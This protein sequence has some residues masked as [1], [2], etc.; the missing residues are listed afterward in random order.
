MNEIYQ[1]IAQLELET[2]LDVKTQKINYQTNGADSLLISKKA[3]SNKL[4]VI[5]KNV[6]DANRIEEELSFFAPNIKVEIFQ[7]N[8]VIPYERISPSNTLIANRVS[9]LWNIL[10][11]KLDVVIIQANIIQNTLPPPS[12]ILG[13]VFDFKVGDRLSIAQLRQNLT[14]SEYVLVDKVIAMGE[15]AIRGGVI[16]LMLMGKQDLIRIELFDD[17]IESLRYVDIETNKTISSVDSIQIFPTK[18][19]PVDESA[20]NLLIEQLQNYFVNNV[21][22]NFLIKEL[23]KGIL[24]L[25][26]EFYLP[27]FFTNKPTIFDYLT[28]DYEII[29]F[30]GLHQEL[31]NNYFDIM[32]RYNIYSFQYPCM[33]PIDLYIPTDSIFNKINQF[34]HYKFHRLTKSNDIKLDQISLLPDIGVN[35][36]LG[37]PCHKLEAFITNFAGVV[38]ICLDSIGRLEIIKTTLAKYQIDSIKFKNLI[39]IEASLYNGFICNNIAFITE[40]ELYKLDITPDFRLKRK[41]KQN[42][43]ANNFN[44]DTIVHDLAEININDYVVHITYGIGKYLG[45]ITQ[46]IDNIDYDMLELEYANGSK[47]FIPINNLQLISKYNQLDGMEVNL[48]QL[49]ANQWHKLKQKIEKK[50]TDIATNLLELYAKREL[51]VGTK[52]VIPQEYQDFSNQFGYTPTIDQDNAFDLVIKKMTQ[53]KPM[54]IL[55]CG[56]VGFGKTEVAIRAA[57]IAAMN[58]MQVAILCPTTLLTEQ[59]YQ[60]FINRFAT[61]PLKIAEISRFRSKKEIATILEQVK[62]GTIDILIG[63]HRLIQSDIKFKN[64]GLVIIDEEHRFGVKQKEKLKQLCSNVDSM[65]LTATPI[66]R[67]LSMAM[68]GVRDFAIIATPPQKRLAV[69]TI[70]CNEDKQILH[71]A[72]YRELRRGGQIF[73]LYNEVASIYD[74]Y[75]KLQNLFP[76]INIAIAHGQMEEKHLE[77]TIREFIQHKYNMLLCST[78]IETGIDIPNANTIF[79]YRADKLGLA[80]LHQLR[81]R[82]GR[83]H[84]QAYCYLIV[85]ENMTKDAEKRIEAI[86]STS[87]LGSGFNLALHDLEI[88]GAGE[89]LGEK[90]SGDIKEVGLSMYTDLLKKAIKNIKQGKTVDTIIDTNNCEVI[91]NVSSIIPHNYCYN[92]QE[93]LIYYKKLASCDNEQELEVIY[94]NI[95]DS[96]GIAPQE[97]KNL[98]NCHT[99]RIKANYL[100]IDKVD[101]NNK[102]I[103]IT[104][105]VNTKID[106]SQLFLFMQQLKTCRMQGSNKLIWTIDNGSI[107][108]KINNA[109]YLLDNLKDKINVNN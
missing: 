35:N 78:I 53:K 64:L 42:Y 34:N 11:N 66:P 87:K 33:K 26:M 81:G 73:F 4:L 59:H 12:F 47:L 52:F 99:L 61:Y 96:Y 102:Q 77:T 17:E 70:V 85:P 93:R 16:D 54:D 55:I 108:D 90:Q 82:V 13:R 31:E 94:Q 10:N 68:D 98:I 14:Q 50:V 84:H 21:E 7:D 106:P 101:I 37:N 67:S 27:L 28:A 74:M 39:L 72:I 95:M 56:D 2:F 86:K 100:L 20:I 15:F 62:L 109:N 23:K 51:E 48:T 71:E 89:I 58:G 41:I 83:S 36:S 80:Q 88:R 43:V 9:T 38:V 3:I 65:A 92:I 30:D 69:N 45:L 104:F 103:S 49:G 1:L 97:L 18:E 25:E 29:Y 46:S 22:I 19:Y 63:T 107:H 40:R 105:N 79:I 60:N 6:F 32:R 8:E 75:L 91:L 76:E 44:Y 5:A 24:P 57:F